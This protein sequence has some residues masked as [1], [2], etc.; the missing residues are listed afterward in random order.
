MTARDPF[1][2]LVDYSITIRSIAAAR[3]CACSTLA[4][5]RLL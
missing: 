4:D 2:L 1:S 3:R 5:T